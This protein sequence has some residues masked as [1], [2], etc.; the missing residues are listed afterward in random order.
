M[1]DELRYLL[2]GLL[3]S[4]LWSSV[5]QRLGKGGD[6]LRGA[7]TPVVSGKVTLSGSILGKPGQT[8]PAVFWG[9]NLAVI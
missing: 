7:P 2:T 1:K 8:A 5:L 6:L 4:F 3:L 9:E